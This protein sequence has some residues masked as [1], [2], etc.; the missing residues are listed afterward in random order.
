MKKLARG[1]ELGQ[2]STVRGP[3]LFDQDAPTRCNFPEVATQPPSDRQGS[4]WFPRAAAGQPTSA[5]RPVRE[6][7]RDVDEQLN[8]C[9]AV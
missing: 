4:E 2:S 1:E 8:V 9:R 5:S 6:D 3:T 7:T